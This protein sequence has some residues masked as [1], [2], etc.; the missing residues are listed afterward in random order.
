ML[1]EVIAMIDKKYYTMNFALGLLIILNIQHLL[2]SKACIAQVYSQTKKAESL[3]LQERLKYF[4]KVSELELQTF[5]IELCYSRLL[6][7]IRNYKLGVAQSLD[8]GY[9]A[10]SPV[11]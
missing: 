2:F 1:Y 6:T 10:I 3:E 7:F 8:W 11:V 9:R 4:C 5:K